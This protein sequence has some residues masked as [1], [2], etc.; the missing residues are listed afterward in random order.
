MPF[1]LRLEQIE[2][3]PQHRFGP[4]RNEL[5]GGWLREAKEVLN[6]LI[7]AVDLFA[8]CRRAH[9]FGL[10][11]GRALLQRPQ[12]GIDRRQWLLDLVGQPGGKLAQVREFIFGGRFVKAQAQPLHH[13]PP[14]NRRKEEEGQST[15]RC[16]QGIE[17][18]LELR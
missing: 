13:H 11:L 10:A 7:Q 6:N 4:E 12:P 16:Q 5:G 18:P 17:D 8:D 15:H 1:Q 2:H 3:F 9:V 14:V